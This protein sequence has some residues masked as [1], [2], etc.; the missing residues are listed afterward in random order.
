MACNTQCSQDERESVHQ[1]QKDLDSN[2]R[3]DEIGQDLFGDYSMLLD[4][5]GEV[6]KPRSCVEQVSMIVQQGTT[7]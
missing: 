4:E 3:V 7:D 2:D 6:I 5:F 1:N